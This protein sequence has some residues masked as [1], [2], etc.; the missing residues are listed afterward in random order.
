MFED[1]AEIVVDPSL[2]EQW[3]RASQRTQQLLDT[4][5]RSALENE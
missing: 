5:W 3:M 1:F 2:R 4:V